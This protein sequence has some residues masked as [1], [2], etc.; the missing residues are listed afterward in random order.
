M[1]GSYFIICLLDSYTLTYE[2][3]GTMLENK[4]KMYKTWFPFK[5]FIV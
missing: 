2:M 4:L 3:P 1:N 5:E